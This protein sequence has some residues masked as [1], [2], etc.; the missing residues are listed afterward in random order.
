MHYSYLDGKKISYHLMQDCRTF[1]RLQEAVGLK[2]A[3][4]QGSIAYGAPP[5][6]LLPNHGDAT[7][8]GQFATCSQNNGGYTQSRGHMAA[9]IQ[10]V[11]KSKKSS[12]PYPDK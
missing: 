6:P 7:T 1:F 9:M 5:P 3:D 11:P 10:P 8:Q 4:T 12:A 2:Q